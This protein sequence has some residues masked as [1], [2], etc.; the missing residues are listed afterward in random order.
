MPKPR[1]CGRHRKLLSVGEVINDA[2]F[3]VAHRKPHLL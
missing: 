2:H 1:V 3:D